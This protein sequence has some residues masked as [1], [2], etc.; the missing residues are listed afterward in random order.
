VT[1]ADL[2]RKLQTPNVEVP[3]NYT[4]V[5]VRLRDGRTARGF[6]RKETLHNLQLQTLEGR[7]LLLAENEY[8]IVGP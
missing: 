5:T 2:V 8:Q 6:A 1:V 7:L 3:A 4:V